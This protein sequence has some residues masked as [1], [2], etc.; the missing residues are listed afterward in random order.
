MQLLFQ[1]PLDKFLGEENLNKE[2][3]ALSEASSQV[4]EYAGKLR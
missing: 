1:A 4:V 2:F 3:R